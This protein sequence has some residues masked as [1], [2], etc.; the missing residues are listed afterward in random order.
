MALAQLPLDFRSNVLVLVSKRRLSSLS[1]SE[2]WRWALEVSVSWFYWRCFVILRKWVSPALTRVGWCWLI[3]ALHRVIGWS[4]CM[5][6]GMIPFQCT[7]LRFGLRKALLQNRKGIRW[8]AREW[9]MCPGQCNRHKSFQSILSTLPALCP[10]IPP[11]LSF[12][13]SL[14]EA[15]MILHKS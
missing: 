14:A 5:C 2:F 10:F 3:P 4:D 7:L 11:Q 12:L 13:C 9:P 6:S 8:S 15:S 1:W